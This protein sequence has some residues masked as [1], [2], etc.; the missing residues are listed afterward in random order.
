[1]KVRNLTAVSILS[2]TALIL[3]VIEAQIP[4]L[5]PIPGIKLGLSNVVTVFTSYALSRKKAGLV[6]ALR[7][8]LGGIFTGQALALIYS[9]SG[10]VLSYMLLCVIKRFFGKRQMWAVSG[11][12]AIVHNAAQLGM[13]A[14]I[15]R[16]AAVF[17]YA[18]ALC[19]SGV[20]TGV[21]TGLAAQFT[22]LALEKSG[23][24][25]S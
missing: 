19:I 11:F 5:I 21:F 9:V 20:I 3:F 1:M 12:C 8:I 6:L 25:L 14:L 16:T 7:V 17:W 4:T 15:M 22:L 23:V 24:K 2:A 10:A 18:P 13:A